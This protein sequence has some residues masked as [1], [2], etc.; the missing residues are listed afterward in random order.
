MGRGFM[1][2]PREVL[3]KWLRSLWEDLFVLLTASVMWTVVGLGPALVLFSVGLAPL[4]FIALLVAAPPMTMGVYYVTNRLA[5]DYVGKFEHIFEGARQYARPAWLLAVVNLAIAAVL[6]ANYQFYAPSEEGPRIIDLAGGAQFQI[7][8]NSTW[9]VAARSILFSIALVWIYSQL[10]ALPMLLEQKV[11]SIW[12][13]MRNSLFLAFGS[14]ALTITLTIILL[15][16]GFLILLALPQFLRWLPFMLILPSMIALLTN[17][18]VVQRLK[19]IRSGE[20]AGE[21]R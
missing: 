15:I 13:A 20:Q 4:G 10:Y 6:W 1:G 7:D 18:A 2:G 11:P 8:P 17:I 9:A 5:H 14:P 21:E 12:F 3:G 16:L 19:A